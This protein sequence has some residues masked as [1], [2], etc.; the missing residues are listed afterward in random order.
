ML[1]DVGQVGKWLFDLKLDIHSA[2]ISVV[3]AAPGSAVSR[4]ISVAIGAPPGA[5]LFLSDIAEELDAARAAGM[6]TILLARAP[7]RC[8][9]RSA[10]ACVA[11]FDAIVPD[12]VQFVDGIPHTATGKILKT[13]LRDQFKSYR[14]PNAAA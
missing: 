3:A 13:A 14:F 8:P 4:F 11:A 2:T 9:D 6:Q 10:H 7:S 12:D 1:G 5:I